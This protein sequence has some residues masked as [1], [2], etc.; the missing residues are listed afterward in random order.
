ME[1]RW[2]PVNLLRGVPLPVLQ[3]VLEHIL[4]EAYVKPEKVEANDILYHKIHAGMVE[5]K[6][7]LA[8]A[9]EEEKLYIQIL[10]KWYYT[11]EQLYTESK[12]RLLFVTWKPYDWIKNLGS[13]SFGE[14][15]SIY[16]SLL[17]VVNLSPEKFSPENVLWVER[18]LHTLKT[19]DQMGS[20]Q[21][22][23]YWCEEWLSCYQANRKD[24]IDR[25]K[26]PLAKL[27]YIEESSYTHG[28]TT[29][30]VKLY[31]DD[32]NHW[33]YT[34]KY[35]LA[36]AHN[37]YAYAWDRVN[38][39]PIQYKQTDSYDS[40][41]FSEPPGE[42]EYQEYVP[43]GARQ[44]HPRGADGFSI[45]VNQRLCTVLPMVFSAPPASIYVPV[46]TSRHASGTGTAGGQAGHRHARRGL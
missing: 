43:E 24:R 38:G 13:K 31:Q 22:A 16:S 12:I 46:G 40:D 29:V 44:A 19:S 15:K 39:Y 34:N 41:Q 33:Y 25:N 26:A 23:I 20:N 18:L 28:D 17:C 9:N 21:D 2:K 4:K 37:R 14:L 6:K 32:Y 3:G 10:I 8:V 35:S 30:E 45:C 1:D 11:W 27:T 36:W 7:N 42:A 5:C